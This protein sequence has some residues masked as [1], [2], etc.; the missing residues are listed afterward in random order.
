MEIPLYLSRFAMVAFASL[1]LVPAPLARAAADSYDKES[2]VDQYGDEAPESARVARISYLDG[3]ASVRQHGSTDWEEVGRNTPL[4]VG[5]EIYTSDNSRLE[6]QLGGGRYLRLFERTDVVIAE[7]GSDYVRVEV[8]AGAVIVSLQHLE[9]G[10]GFEVSAPAASV[11][12]RESGVYRVDVDDSGDTRVAV[13]SGRLEASGIEQALTL[14]SGEVASFSYDTPDYVDVS[15]LLGSDDFDSWSQGQDN[16]YANAYSNSSSVSSLLY[17]TDIYGLADLVSYGSWVNYGS[18]GYCWRPSVASGWQP[19][20]NGYWQWY[21][22]YG[23]TWVSSEPWGWAPYHNGRWLFDAQ[24]GWVWVPWS[25]YSGGDYYWRP[26]QAYWYQYPGYNGYAWVPLAPNEPYVS[27]YSLAR[28]HRANQNYV[29]VH[30][31]NRQGINVAPLPGSSAR[32]RPVRPGNDIIGRQPVLNAPA[33]PTRFSPVKPK[34]D[35]GRAE[36]L[37]L[38]PVVVRNPAVGG[39]KPRVGADDA[40]PRRPIKVATNA[41]PSRGPV[42]THGRS[43]QPHADDVPSMVRDGRRERAEAPDKPVRQAGGGRDVADDNTPAR[44]PRESVKPVKERA[45]DPARVPDAPSNDNPKPRRVEPMRDRDEADRPA[46]RRIEEPSQNVDRPKPRRADP[47]ASGG[48]DDSTRRARKPSGDVRPDRPSQPYVAP[49]QDP[50]PRRDVD[51][52]K[53]HHDQPRADPPRADPPRMDS[54]P[55]R[56]ERA[57]DAGGGGHRSKP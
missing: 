28:R 26:S 2:Y 55:P 52:P 36:G 50:P 19:Y 47:P 22:G 35:V 57:P 9:R 41:T 10:E 31:R 4:F 13:Q 24:Y 51:A 45:A 56:I 46:P 1:L 38:K 8:P 43:K 18:Y 6:I 16:A 17:R 11:T 3:E 27:Y 12:L 14:E 32:L 53:P 7:I 23:Y 39:A 40:L 48:D 21:P 5:D 54:P 49:R 44:M 29:P 20:S 33:R 25:Q 30:L 42:E 34:F 15:S 37:R